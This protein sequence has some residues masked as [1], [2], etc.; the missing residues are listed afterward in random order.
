MKK[1]S[2][3]V[4]S[5]VVANAN[6]KLWE[7]SSGEGVA[8]AN[9]HAKEDCEV[10]FHKGDALRLIAQTPDWL[11][12]T[13]VKNGSRGLCP[14]SYV[15]VAA[16]ADADRA[17]HKDLLN[18]LDTMFEEVMIASDAE[19]EEDEEVMKAAAALEAEFSFDNIMAE[20]MAMKPE[21]GKA[22]AAKPLTKSVPKPPPKVDDYEL[23]SASGR[24]SAA[25]DFMDDEIPV[26]MKS[27]PPPPE[28]TVMGDDEELSALTS[29]APPPQL[30]SVALTSPRSVRRAATPPNVGSSPGGSGR[31]SAQPPTASI[32]SSSSAIST[33]PTP[34]NPTSKAD[35]FV[36]A[37]TAGSGSIS[38]PNIPR[39]PTARAIAKLLNDDGTMR[40]AKC[41]TTVGRD[42][43][44]CKHCGSVLK[45][46]AAE[47][48]TGCKLLLKPGVAAC[49]GC[50]TRTSASAANSAAPSPNLSAKNASIPVPLVMG[51]PRK[52]A[53]QQQQQQQLQQT[54]P[55]TS[56]SN[57]LAA[58]VPTSP[59]RSATQLASQPSTQPSPPQ[60]GSPRRSLTKNAS[61]S[62][63]AKVP[64]LNSPSG[65]SVAV[66]LPTAPAA[67][68]SAAEVEPSKTRV[69]MVG[70]G[71]SGGTPSLEC[72]AGERC[73]TCV[74]A[75]LPNS[76][77]RRR[78]PSLLIQHK[79]FNIL[80]DCGKTFRESWIQVIEKY[81]VKVVHAVII[82]HAHA[83]AFM[84]LDDLREVIGR[85]G[86]SVP[87]YAR[88][89]DL[90]VIKNCFPYLTEE[91]K[92]TSKRFTTNVTFKTLPPSGPF[93]VC[94]LKFRAI[95]VP[96][97][98]DCTCLGFQFGPVVYLSD[99]SSVP[100][101]VFEFLRKLPMFKVLIIDALSVKKE[102]HAH[103]N[104]PQALNII[105]HAMPERAILT[106]CGHEFFYSDVRRVLKKVCATEGIRVKLGYDLLHF[107]LDSA[108]FE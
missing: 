56:S 101:R 92:A 16:K 83:D 94:G 9:Y 12:V 89:C 77:N 103:L 72:I 30:V 31:K 20:V 37:R 82:T 75:L 13:V 68:W 96:H 73:K 98:D 18:E 47:Y 99:L 39:V 3:Q 19:R 70:S 55:Q 54:Q 17:S 7:A 34:A 107:S 42:A 95:P 27:L 78:N 1:N 87:V 2:P 4:V 49:G 51:S 69:I 5:S 28:E 41:S 44:F 76:K 23:S 52:S 60:I 14:I 43:T 65:V 25:D 58:P 50:G 38:S 11:R 91:R 102:Y 93:E 66:P 90:E 84:G 46:A 33:L 62:V 8:R 48:C 61:G 106:G 59:R 53:A 26:P 36:V 81:E 24:S 79:G 80:I 71:S 97:G 29:A 6:A 74:D 10:S 32:S 100:D 57:L 40:C 108:L 45:Q 85:E 88:D 22:A 86:A 63:V 67:R 64:S 104:L 105:K 15:E 35:S 21:E